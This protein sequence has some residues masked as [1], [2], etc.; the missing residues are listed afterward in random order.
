MQALLNWARKYLPRAV[1]DS[2]DDH[3]GYTPLGHA[4]KEG[5]YDMV[6]FLVSQGAGTFSSVL[7]SY[8]SFFSKD[9]LPIPHVGADMS[10]VDAMELTPLH[11]A[12]LQHDA[13]MVTLLLSLGAKNEDNQRIHP[14]TLVLHEH[15]PH[16]MC[17]LL[18][19]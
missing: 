15:T 19:F 10:A 1:I 12:V 3:S 11:L 7:L 4:V 8:H 2:P 17:P 14:H 16:G 6:H 13:R 5:L 9:C 18:K